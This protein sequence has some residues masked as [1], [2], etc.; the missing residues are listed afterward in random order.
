LV[1]RRLKGENPIAC[2]YC[3]YRKICDEHI[4]RTLKSLA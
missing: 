1:Q 2:I 3:K 4:S